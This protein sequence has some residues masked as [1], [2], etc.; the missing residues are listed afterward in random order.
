MKHTRRYWTRSG[1]TKHLSLP[2][3]LARAFIIC[4]LCPLF[5]ITSL[6][7]AQKISRASSAER[8]CLEAETMM[9][10]SIVK[11]AREIGE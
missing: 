3:F 1:N 2:S 6:F 11:Q 9:P 8:L 10:T 4:F 5:L 7:V